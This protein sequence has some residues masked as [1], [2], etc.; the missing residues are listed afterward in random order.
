MHNG[1]RSEFLPQPVD[2]VLRIRGCTVGRVLAYEDYCAR[3]LALDLRGPLHTS[4]YALYHEG[5]P[6]EELSQQPKAKTWRIHAP[7]DFD[8]DHLLISLGPHTAKEDM[9]LFWALVDL[10]VAFCTVS[11]STR[12]GDIIVV[13]DGGYKPIVLRKVGSRYISHGP[14]RFVSE[15]VLHDGDPRARSLTTS[16][17]VIQTLFEIAKRFGRLESYDIE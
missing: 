12:A 4:R 8:V 2:G 13:A 6:A 5:K 11:V 16:M 15:R 10:G 17:S 1:K 14:A 9:D 7:I 3:R